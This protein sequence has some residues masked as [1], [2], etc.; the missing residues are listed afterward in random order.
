MNGLK[1]STFKKNSSCKIVG[2]SRSGVQDR[3]L[4]HL[5]INNEKDISNTYFYK[6][7]E[8]SRTDNLSKKD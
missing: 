4:K 6:F 3:K 5:I 8:L 1:I 7:M 2:V